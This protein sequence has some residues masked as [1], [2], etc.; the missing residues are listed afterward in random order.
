[1]KQS[2]VNQALEIILHRKQ[3]A[4]AKAQ[5]AFSNAFKNPQFKNAYQALQ[6]A[7]MQKAKDDA[8]A[9][10]NDGS[11]L[12]KCQNEYENVKKSLKIDN[13]SPN[14]HCNK[15][16]DNGIV[17]GEYCTCL[18]KQIALILIKNSGFDQLEDFK[19]SNFSI[20]ENPENAKKIYALMQKWCTSQSQKTLIYMFGQTGTG[21]T[22]LAKCMAKQLI[23]QAKICLLISAFALNQKFLQIH[24]ARE[25]QKTE[26]LDELLSPEVLFIDDLGTEPIYKNVTIEYLY[27]LIN[28]RQTRGL[29]TVITSNLDPESIMQRYDER[30]FSRIVNKQKSIAFELA[31]KDLRVK[32][33]D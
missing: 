32:K 22:H 20:F 28:E 23:Q 21:K 5:E 6:Q 15:C 33:K 3:L 30:I 14:Y 19:Q 13:L 2:L 7:I 29:R 10:K 26:L 27:L 12:K 1:M 18:K 16:K 8:F 11:Q 25:E 31:G 17:D 9:I 24:T 4:E